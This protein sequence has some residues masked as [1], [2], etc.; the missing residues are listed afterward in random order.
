MKSRKLNEQQLQKLTVLVGAF[1]AAVRT[2]KKAPAITTLHKNT[3]HKG[4]D[5]AYARK[6]L[7][8]MEAAVA[9][10]DSNGAARLYRDN[11]TIDELMPLVVEMWYTIVTP[12]ATRKRKKHEEESSEVKII[13]S[14]KPES[15]P[16][17]TLNDL[18]KAIE[19]L[20]WEVTL[21]HIRK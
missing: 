11:R 19:D 17:M 10:I 6:F 2:S 16:K 8:V 15:K 3:F 4:C 18:V 5:A 14:K 1:I 12:D 7:A 20:G 13:D 21:K 9:H